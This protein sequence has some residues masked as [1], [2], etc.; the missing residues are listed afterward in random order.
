MRA[1]G[2]AELS[3]RCVPARRLRWIVAGVLG[4]LFGIG[5]TLV[6]QLSP[7]AV[8]GTPDS[9]NCPASDDV[10]TVLDSSVSIR[11]REVATDTKVTVTMRHTTPVD[12]AGFVAAGSDWGSLV[13]TLSPCILPKPYILQSFQWHDGTFTGHFISPPPYPQPLAKLFEDA[14]VE[15]D[16]SAHSLTVQIG[17]CRDRDSNPEPAACGPRAHT[18]VNFVA[19]AATLKTA[20]PFIVITPFTNDSGDPTAGDAVSNINAPMPY[21]LNEDRG[22]TTYVWNFTGPPPAL[23]FT[24]Q[25]PPQLN[26]ALWLMG[27]SFHGH[28]GAVPIFAEILLCATAAAVLLAGVTIAWIRDQ[29]WRFRITSVLRGVSLAVAVLAG[30]VTL[31]VAHFFPAL[32]AVAVVGAS[33]ALVILSVAS[34]W[35][36][37]CFA[38]TVLALLIASLVCAKELSNRGSIQDARS[39]S[40]ALVVLVLTSAAT[41]AGTYSVI[42]QILSIV[43]LC[44]GITS[45]NHP[46]PVVIGSIVAFGSF[47]FFGATMSSAIA[48]CVQASKH[49]KEGAII[50]YPSWASRVS[51]WPGCLSGGFR[52]T[53]AILGVFAPL[54]AVAMLSIAWI[55]HFKASRS[56]TEQLSSN[57]AVFRDRRNLTRSRGLPFPVTGVIA[58]L[59]SIAIAEPAPATNLIVAVWLWLIQFGILYVV[60]KLICTRTGFFATNAIREKPWTWPAAGVPHEREGLVAALRLEAQT[61]SDGSYVSDDA[62]RLLNI[63]PGNNTLSNARWAASCAALLSFGPVAYTLWEITRGIGA[64]GDVVANATLA[65]FGG[66]ATLLREGAGWLITGF[67]FGY[68]YSRLP[69][70][71]GPQKALVLVG[72]W[73]AS[74]GMAAACATIVGADIGEVFAYRAAEFSVFVIVLGVIYDWCSIRAGGG[75]WRDQRQVYIRNNYLQVTAV[76]APLLVSVVTLASQ[77]SSGAGFQT[78]NTLV[79]GFRDTISAPATPGRR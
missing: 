45:P 49:N 74:A 31:N 75:N 26:F 23:T 47:T 73:W 9:I 14:G 44:R 42:A 72:V 52:Q 40:I 20:P 41:I 62:V 48:L 4:S 71:T 10:T 43:Q 11:R 57:R 37:R 56:A 15:A 70:K 60:L 1:R 59:L 28:W 35:R 50:P 76:L 5:F 77:I 38:I 51:D 53:I 46:V 7:P 17:L 78:A 2:E 39:A 68:L 8:V 18:I 22:K 58:L 16:F 33:W 27:Q 12:S 63:G 32:C 79:N 65:V 25:P 55:V 6:G 19:D 34:S 54:I 24:L 64:D 3:E 69:G 61:R 13:D 67:V 30:P 29:L 21:Q 36:L 66:T